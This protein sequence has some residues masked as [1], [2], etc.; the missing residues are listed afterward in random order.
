M[1][2]QVI[3]GLKWVKGEIAMTLRR[4]RGQVERFARGGAPADLA[5]AID[6]L[7]EV[8]GVLLALQ[9][10]LPARLVDEMQRLCD[11]MAEQRVPSPNEAVEA[12]LLALVQLPGHLDQLDAG[13]EV[14]PLGLWPTINDLRASRGAPPVT[15]AE[16]LVPGSVLAV[17]EEELSP[18][19]LEALGVAL[20][21][22]RPHFHRHLV[23]WFGPYSSGEGLV[24]LSRLF[25][26]LHRFLKEGMLSDLFRLA[27]AHAAGLQRG[28][29]AADASARALVS[30]LDRVFKPLS[31]AVPTW[32]ESEIRE[33]LDT[34]LTELDQ[35]DIQPA[36]VAEVRAH[37]TRSALESGLPSSSAVLAGL[38]E[39]ML[40]ELAVLKECLSLFLRGERDD[41]VP[42]ETLR[43]GTSR[44]AQ[45]LEEAG[46]NEVAVRL[47]GLAQGFQDLAQ[48]DADLDLAR[49]E[50]LVGGLLE[51][52]ALFQAQAQPTVPSAW[53][54]QADPVPDLPVLV[55]LDAPW[56][57]APRDS[58]YA[59]RALAPGLVQSADEPVDG[60]APRSPGGPARR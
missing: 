46:N 47:R 27:A 30:R 31:A 37:Y 56:L 3:G 33:L 34:F 44:L 9:L 15:P 11:A 28:Q 17:E 26:Q 58:G 23:E 2:E 14:P 21:K 8:R 24:K 1:A 51:I 41:R 52:E 57:P 60:A 43:S 50:P 5:E 22:V 19:A 18:E 38:A 35:S 16:L 59:A 55:D 25:Q 29:V 6:A 36:L 45:A 20:R 42:L 13:A 49:L 10:A 54:D 53:A 4:V 32:P 48:S 7:F 40:G 39:T 12:L